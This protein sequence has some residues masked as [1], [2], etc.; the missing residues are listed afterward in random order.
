MDIAIVKLPSVV[1][2]HLSRFTHDG[3]KRDNL[4]DFGLRGVQLGQF[5]LP[6]FGNSFNRFDLYGVTNHIGST[7]QNGHYTAFC[8][9]QSSRLWYKFN[10]ESVSV[11]DKD[12]IGTQ[13]AYILY[14]A[15]DT[16]S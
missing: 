16:E 13:A 3:R 10:D 7:V 5:A 6:G 9:R 12:D 8:Y 14:Y 1:I 15:A 2:F 4:V 11:V